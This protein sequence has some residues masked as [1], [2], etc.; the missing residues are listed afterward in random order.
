MDDHSI[1]AVCR[2]GSLVV[3]DAP[4]PCAQRPRARFGCEA[5]GA[6]VVVEDL[7]QADL[8]DEAVAHVFACALAMRTPLSVR[9]LDVAGAPVAVTRHHPGLSL[10]ELLGLLALDDSGRAPH[11]LVVA[12]GLAVARALALFPAALAPTDDAQAWVRF[13]GVIEAQP[14]A[15]YPGAP[16]LTST[17]ATRAYLS[18]EE[19]DLLDQPLD[20]A[21]PTRREPCFV[22][23]VGVVLHRLLFGEHPYLP[24]V[25]EVDAPRRLDAWVVDVAHLVGS[26]RRV[27]DR[28]HTGV[29]QLAMQCTERDPQ[30]RPPLAAVVAALGTGAGARFDV[31]GMVAALAPT[32]V[33]ERHEVGEQ[34]ALVDADD[35][36]VLRSRPL[37]IE[38]WRAFLRLPEHN[39]RPRRRSVPRALP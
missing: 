8:D 37:D 20:Q 6:V 16:A 39:A 7:V 31:H 30:R 3:T 1:R 19:A 22:F 26:P 21:L 11:E 25:A 15:T 5:G 23:R 29:A 13:D 24:R 33:R 18:P 35:V 27:R 38:P 36:P 28:G 12:A 4:H 2:L 17:A 14:R 34:V 10:D 32:L 9:A